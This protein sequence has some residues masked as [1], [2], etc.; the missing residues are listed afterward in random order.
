M[1]TWGTKLEQD[2]KFLDTYQDFFD[3][4]NHGYS[5]AKITE[6]LLQQAEIDDI[7][8]DDE[9]THPFWFALAKAQWE[10]GALQEAVFE[11]VKQI[12]N[13]GADI[14]EWE[15]RNASDK[16]LKAREKVLQNFLKK[17]SIPH[18]FVTVK[19]PKRPRLPKA[20]YKTGECIAYQGEN[21]KWYGSICLRHKEEDKINSSLVIGLR[22]CQDT[23]PT[24]QDFE[25]A[26]V[27][28]CNFGSWQNS[29]DISWQSKRKS[30]EMGDYQLIG[31]IKIVEPAHFD[32]NSYG[33]FAVAFK[34]KTLDMQLAYEAE[35][36][37]KPQG[38]TLQEILKRG[39]GVRYDNLYL[40]TYVK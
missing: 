19:Q 2:D 16:D 33:G 14:E 31:K 35:G 5:V 18:D 1:G 39:I 13:S 20:P 21:G 36:N 37:P 7:L 30:A 25:Q 29:L 12:I 4:Y 40:Q 38:Y 22:I 26:E 23:L 11:K 15:S 28:I 32:C 10:C 17:I 34:Y 24:L 9:D 3:E 8:E 27:L 6:K